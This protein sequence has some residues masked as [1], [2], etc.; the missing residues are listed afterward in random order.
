MSLCGSVGG[1]GTCLL[2]RFRHCG[3]GDISESSFCV[4][5]R[6][7]V[8]CDGP[9]FLSLFSTAIE[10]SKQHD[11]LF[12]FGLESSTVSEAGMYAFFPIQSVHSFLYVTARYDFSF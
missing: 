5:A 3:G 2:P 11:F 8:A 7:A 6:K 10:G 9:P 1:L 4:C 12:C